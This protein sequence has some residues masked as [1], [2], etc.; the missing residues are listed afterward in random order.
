MNNQLFDPVE[1][2]LPTSTESKRQEIAAVRESKTNGASPVAYRQGLAAVRRTTE[3][4]HRQT[5]AAR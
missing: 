3:G 4:R 2:R 5:Y 1:N